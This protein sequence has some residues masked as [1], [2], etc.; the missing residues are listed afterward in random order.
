[1]KSCSTTF[2]SLRLLAEISTED[3]GKLLLGARNEYQV[4]GCYIL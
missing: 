3:N 2:A 1:M 4:V